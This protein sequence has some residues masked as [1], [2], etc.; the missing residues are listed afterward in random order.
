MAIVDDHAAIAAGLRRR[1]SERY[2]GLRPLKIGKAPLKT[3]IVARSGNLPVGDHMTEM[4]AW[5]AEQNI[6]ERELIMLHVLNFRIV[7]RATFDTADQADRF[8][9]QF[10]DRRTHF[11]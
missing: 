3:V 8:T 2:P 1:Q 7:F 9:A 11:L 10:G 4:R 6:E 5:L